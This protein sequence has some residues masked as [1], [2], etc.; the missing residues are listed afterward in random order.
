MRRLRSGTIRTSPLR[1]RAP[2]PAPRLA[3]TGP[4]RASRIPEPRRKRRR[5]AALPNTP[6]PAI[7]ASTRGRTW[8][9]ATEQGVPDEAG[10]DPVARL[11]DVPRGRRFP[12]PEHNAVPG[13]AQPVRARPA[14]G[15]RSRAAARGKRPLGRLD[16]RG[17]E[18][19]RAHV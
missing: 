18:I 8:P 17:G 4:A 6:G 15:G 9:G 3:G 5:V 11:A 16:V 19:G 13:S 14:G 12:L 7:P 1:V 2:F 10:L